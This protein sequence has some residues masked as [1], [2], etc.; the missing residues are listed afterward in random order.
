MTNDGELLVVGD[1]PAS[2]EGMRITTAKSGKQL[3]RGTGLVLLN[4]DTARAHAA[5]KDPSAV[6]RERERP[7]EPQRCLA[8]LLHFERNLALPQVDD[9]QD[10]AVPVACR[11]KGSGDNPVPG[12]VEHTRNAQAVA[13]SQLRLVP[14]APGIFCIDIAVLL[15]SALREGL[16]IAGAVFQALRLLPVGWERDGEQVGHVFEHIGPSRVAQGKA[17]VLDLTWMVD[18]CRMEGCKQESAVISDGQDASLVGH[19][20]STSASIAGEP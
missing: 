8:R 13:A 11:G 12:C 18:G 7:V 10:G 6:V 20:S 2:F 15:L 9:A 16:R 4:L 19:R 1:D 17:G 14:R 3:E 5:K